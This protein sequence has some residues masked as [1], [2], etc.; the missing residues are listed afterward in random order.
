MA[1]TWLHFTDLHLGDR[2]SRRDWSTVRDALHRDLD[3]CFFGE[4]PRIGRPD[5][6]LFT[7]DLSYSGTE[8]DRVEAFL[9]WLDERAGEQLPAF[10]VPGNHDLQWV[11]E[12]RRRDLS[13]LRSTDPDDAQH[14]EQALGE[15]PALLA[16]PFARGRTSRPGACTRGS[17]TSRAA[18]SPATPPAPS[19]REASAWACWA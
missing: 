13:W 11:E 16:A 2:A 17:P 15:E 18:C 4:K 6:V 3:R 9:D 14:R 7:G 5:L 19:R 8:F 1:L 10:A 12:S